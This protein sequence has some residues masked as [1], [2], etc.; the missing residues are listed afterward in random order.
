MIEGKE[1]LFVFLVCFVVK[2]YIFWKIFYWNIYLLLQ[3][4][5]KKLELFWNFNI[6]YYK[7]LFKYLCLLY[8]ICIRVLKSNY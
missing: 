4:K 7:I 8:C 5:N 3:D 2:Y 6:I 1:K